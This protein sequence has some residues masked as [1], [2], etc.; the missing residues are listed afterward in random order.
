MMYGKWQ[1]EELKILRDCYPIGGRR[2]TLKV[3]AA[4]GYDR[5]LKAIA[6]KAKKEGIRTNGDG[7]YQPGHVPANKGKSMNRATRKKVSRTWFEKSHLPATTLHDG[8]ITKRRDN[9][10]VYN[11]HIRIAKGKWEYLSRHLWKQAHGPIPR[12]RVITYK[13]GDPMNCVLENLEMISRQ[14][15]LRRL[16]EQS[17]YPGAKL[18]DGYVRGVLIRRGIDPDVITPAMVETKK[19]QLILNREIKKNETGNQ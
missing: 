1:E 17:G 10:G 2:Y 14:E 18:S 9:R 16:H 3:L 13:D 8:A 4:E 11:Y 12:N 7:R 6:A 19:L 5:T 15:N